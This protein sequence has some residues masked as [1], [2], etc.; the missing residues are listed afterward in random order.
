MTEEVKVN[1]S[2]PMLVLRIR[3]EYKAP[4]HKNRFLIIK[5]NNVNTRKIFTKYLEQYTKNWS[6]GTYEVQY[7]FSDKG[8][9][10][11]ST[12]ARF[13]VR[14][15]RVSKI[16]KCSLY[17]RREYPCWQYFKVRKRRRKVKK[18]KTKRKKPKKKIRKKKKT[19]KR[20][21]T[22]KKSRKKELPRREK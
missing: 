16:W 18:K 21:V 22:K 19:K 15:G 4:Y 2:K 5:K 13:D 8:P 7:L 14:N 6:N 11:Y 10:L 3:D 20:K 9:N 12:F 1:F 17:T